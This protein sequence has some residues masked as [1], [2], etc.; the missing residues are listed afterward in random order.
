MH[1]STVNPKQLSSFTLNSSLIPPTVVQRLSELIRNVAQT[2][3][4]KGNQG[5]AL[6]SYFSSNAITGQ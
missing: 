3:C 4:S 6:C 1:I 5:Y 2:S